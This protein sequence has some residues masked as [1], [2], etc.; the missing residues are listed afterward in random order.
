LQQK[1]SALS[2]RDSLAAKLAGLQKQQG[3]LE[4]DHPQLLAQPAGAGLQQQ[5]LA[6]HPP[7]ETQQETAVAKPPPPPPPQ[8]ENETEIELVEQKYKAIV[9]DLEKQV[10]AP[11]PILI[12][13]YSRYFEYS[14]TAS[15]C[16]LFAFDDYLL[17]SWLR[18]ALLFSPSPIPATMRRRRTL[19]KRKTKA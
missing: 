6:V 18:P 11:R 4:P 7:D 19:P 12:L 1:Q 13:Q 9:E 3:V 14:S 10:S 5:R 15:F 16:F 17:I 2:Q 8:H